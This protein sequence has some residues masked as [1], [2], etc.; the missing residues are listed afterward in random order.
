MT[1]ETPDPTQL[2]AN[3]PHAEEV[4]DAQA[5]ADAVGQGDHAIPTP[6][7]DANADLE[8]LRRLVAAYGVEG[9]RQMI[10]SLT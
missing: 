3:V 10:D 4:H 9:V 6:G 7:R 1:D 8:L 5:A 2:P